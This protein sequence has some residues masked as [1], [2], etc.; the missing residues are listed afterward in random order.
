MYMVH[1][2]LYPPP[3][4]QKKEYGRR[5]KGEGEGQRKNN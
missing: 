2:L 3:P 4:P 5:I 1:E